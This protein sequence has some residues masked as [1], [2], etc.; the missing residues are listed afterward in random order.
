MILRWEPPTDEEDETLLGYL[1][2]IDADAISLSTSLRLHYRQNSYTFRNLEPLV[3]FHAILEPIRRELP[4]APSAVTFTT[5]V[6][7]YRQ[8]RSVENQDGSYRSETVES[9]VCVYEHCW[10]QLDYKVTL[11]WEHIGC[12]LFKVTSSQ[13]I[14][15]YQIVFILHNF[16]FLM[17]IHRKQR[18][19]HFPHSVTFCNKHCLYSWRSM[20]EI[21]IYSN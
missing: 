21:P 20:L 7:K 9:D 4:T 3:E 16:F 17:H 18:F 2:K 19:L 5:Y 1:L 15:R 12:N 14:W 6:C 10:F 13:V 8:Y 11:Q